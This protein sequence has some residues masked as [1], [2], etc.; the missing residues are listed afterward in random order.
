MAEKRYQR[1][2]IIGSGGFGTVYRATVNGETKEFAWK[3][4]KQNATSNEIRRF[5]REVRIQSQL[6]HPHIMPILAFNLDRDPPAFIM[7]KASHSLL[8]IMTDA[9][10]SQEQATSIFL[11][12]CE[13]VSYAHEQ[14]IVH[15]DLKPAN[16]L[17]VDDEPVVADFGLGREIDRQTTTITQTNINLGTFAYMPPE[18]MK[19]AKSA[20]ELSD[21]YSLGKILYELLTGQLP[22][23]AMELNSVPDGFRYI[24]DKAT[25]TNPSDRFFS[26][27]ELANEVELLTGQKDL[28]LPLLKSAQYLIN[29]ATT[30]G[31]REA[32]C[33]AIRF[34]QKHSTSEQLYQEIVARLPK[35][36]IELASKH[37]NDELCEV[38][39]AFSQH[40]SG[41]LVFSYV[42]V[43]ADLLRAAF[44][45]CNRLT[46]KKTII[47]RLLKM[48][49][50][51]NRY[52]VRKVVQDISENLNTND[53]IMIFRDAAD[54]CHDC[55]GWYE[56]SFSLNTPEII[57][58]TVAKYGSSVTRDN[59]MK[60]R[61]SRS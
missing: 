57:R 58:Q 33:K 34:L 38:I 40:V 51:H 9:A 54:D 56:P 26:V 47:K 17:F 12:V 4:T 32:V 41:Q 15:R 35:R 55:I 49:Q 59:L 13:A 48:G 19:D 61:I 7:P 50:A 42:D 21:I 8:S 53:E 31:D 36:L 44:Y 46:T 29:E 27:G 2:E 43:V 18:Q 20:N 45:A 28:L 37:C 22:F 30:T 6:K 39:D 23:P 16:I 24:V 10:S 1:H 3:Q 14:G 60:S 52:H 5:Q 11:K 25:K